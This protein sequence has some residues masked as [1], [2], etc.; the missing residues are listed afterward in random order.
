M[1][2][3]DRVRSAWNAFRSNEL[4][5][6]SEAY[7]PAG[8]VSYGSG[9]PYKSRRIMGSER[10]IISTIY[11]KIS[12]DVSA[13]VIKHVKVDED[14]RYL[15]D[16]ATALNQCFMLEPNIDQ[17]PRAF[18]QDI[19][20]TLFDKGCAALVPVDTSRSPETNA[21]FDIYSLRV[22]EIV[23]W[24]P[25]H[26]R[27][28]VYNE[29]NGKREEITL[30]KRYVAIVENPLYSVMNEPNST[31][32]RLIRKI[33]LLDGVDEITSSGKLDLIIQLPYTIKTEAR[34]AAAAQRHADIEFQLRGSQY[35]IAYIDGTEKIT[36]LNRP[37]E[38][39]LL[40][41][42]E[43]LTKQLYNQLGLTEE[44]MNGTADEAAMINYNNRT[45]DPIM[46]AIVEAMRR[47]FL[48]TSGIDRE[49]DIMF[50]KD[51]FK[52]VPVSQ[53]AEIADAFTRNEILT[54]NEI[55]QFM[56]IQ[57]S[58]EQK[59]DQLN[60]PNMPQ[61][62]ADTPALPAPVDTS[63]QDAIVDETLSSL[64]KDLDS[65]LSEFGSSNGS[66]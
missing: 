5:V 16:M 64:G 8:T 40:K 38:N 27:V 36:Q 46:T 14:G 60:N 2:I 28:S 32:Q 9:P 1:A 48:G 42:I 18:R 15:D 65:I 6:E 34:R 22:G 54:S 29:A 3:F 33:N 24:F 62:I 51:P 45:V 20:L 10:S 13:L 49:E 4:P 47:S 25:R 30:E 21:I 11:T 50:F 7:Y 63:E 56:G 61:A 23:S 12:V 17:A 55:R 44:V 43:Y 52:L 57:P 53:I 39:N 58:K 66:G 35:G 59:A 41:Q 26:V 31:L 19:A 37:T